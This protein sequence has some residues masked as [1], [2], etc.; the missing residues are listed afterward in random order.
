MRKNQC[1]PIWTIYMTAFGQMKIWHMAI[2][3]NFYD[4]FFFYWNLDLN[5]PLWLF[6]LNLFI[7]WHMAQWKVAT[8]HIDWIFEKQNYLDS[9]VGRQ[10]YVHK[11]IPTYLGY[12]P[13]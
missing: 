4:F 1:G 6:T 10:N 13:T 8:L 3:I 11:K 5:H 7:L 12:I 2:G 9:W